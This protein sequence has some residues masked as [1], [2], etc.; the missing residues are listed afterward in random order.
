[1]FPRLRSFLTTWIQRE[2][3]ED[4][5]DEEIRFHLNAQTEDFV[6]TGVPT[7]GAERRARTLFGIIEAVKDDCWRAR[8]LCRSRP[9]RETGSNIQRGR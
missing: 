5:L 4:S 6:R 1:M 9:S 2:S 7:A 3:F 8:G